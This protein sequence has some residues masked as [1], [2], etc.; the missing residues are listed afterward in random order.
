MPGAIASFRAALRAD[1]TDVDAHISLG[2]MAREVGDLAA[3]V[4]AYE[5]ALKVAPDCV[6]AWYDARLS[7]RA[8]AS[9][10]AQRQPRAPVRERPQSTPPPFRARTRARS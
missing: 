1:G 3:A 5:G 2:N 9:L 7:S 6:M 8:R 10:P 4:G